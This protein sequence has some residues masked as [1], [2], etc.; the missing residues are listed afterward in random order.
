MIRV[1]AHCDKA[2]DTPLSQCSCCQ[3]VAYCDQTCQK[4]DWKRHREWCKARQAS[5]RCDICA[6]VELHLQ[7]VLP[8]HS[9]VMK[10]FSTVARIIKDDRFAVVA[11]GPFFTAARLADMDLAMVALVQNSSGVR[12]EN[13]EAW[14]DDMDIIIKIGHRLTYGSWINM[15]TKL[16]MTLKKLLADTPCCIC[17]EATLQNTGC[18]TCREFICFPCA[19]RWKAASGGRMT[20]PMCRSAIGSLRVRT[21]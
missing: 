6:E 1:C 10:D 4:N 17:H 3:G 2:G 18:L 12:P 14:S 13:T 11:H 8:L 9:S 5:K 16:A 19:Q 21:K 7:G 15:N 20:C